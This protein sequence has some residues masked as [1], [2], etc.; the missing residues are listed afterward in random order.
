MRST[1]AEGL[2]PEQFEK[3]IAKCDLY[4]ATWRSGRR[5]RIEDHL[6]EGDA[7]ACDEFF[8]ELLGLELELR[9]GVGE[10]PMPAEYHARFPDRVKMIDELF[11]EFET[12]DRHTDPHRGGVELTTREFADPTKKRSAG[13]ASLPTKIGKYTVVALLDEGG[14]GQVYRV[15]HT[16]LGKELVLKLARRSVDLDRGARDLV[17]AEGQLLATLE[18]RSLVR[19][20][21]LDFHEGRPF[22]VMEYISGC[23]LQQYAAQQRLPPRKAAAMVGELARVVD[24]LHRRGVVHQ[25]LKPKNVLVEE[26]GQLRLIDFG[27]ARLRHAW[28]ESPDETSGGTLSFMAPEQACGETERVGACSDIFALG[29]ILYYLLTGKAPFDGTSASEVWDRARRNDLDRSSLRAAGAPQSIERVC[30]KAMATDPSERFASAGELAGV[31]ERLARSPRRTWQAAVAASLTLLAVTLAWLLSHSGHVAAVADPLP[32]RDLLQVKRGGVSYE[33][34]NQVIP[35]RTGDLLRIRCALPRG[36][37]PTAYWRDSEGRLSELDLEWEAGE[38]QDVATFPARGRVIPLVGPPGTEFLL[39][40]AGRDGSLLAL[41][42]VE[43]LLGD[44]RPW[45][46]L[47]EGTVLRMDRD[48]VRAEGVPGS[49]GTPPLA[50]EVRTDRGEVSRGL[51]IPEPDLP[52]GV[53]SR[54]VELHRALKDRAGF[55]AGLAFSH[56]EAV[57]AP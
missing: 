13:P 2:S 36:L 17:I 33:D 1:L 20:L 38:I 22:L 25:D 15:V 14:Q 4:E 56:V 30:L 9:Q 32:P 11:R 31:L 53:E 6:N 48:G 43:E 51:G 40:C 8:R 19:I 35:L 18:H 52:G 12:M 46:A 37:R 44:S 10:R 50:T 27:L 41:G 55:L 47:P 39:I 29:G 45:P 42:E 7:P 3:I 54:L 26:S 24:M 23:N 16:G 57:V 5:A 21:D 49:G 34:L 28:A